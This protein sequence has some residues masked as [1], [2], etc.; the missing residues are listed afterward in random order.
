MWNDW[1]VNIVK[2][3][4]VFNIDRLSRNI[5]EIKKTAVGGS[6][7][8]R[9]LSTQIGRLKAN[10]FVLNDPY[11]ISKQL[12]L[13]VLNTMRNI[14]PDDMGVATSREYFNLGWKCEIQILKSI[15]S[16]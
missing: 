2:K 11:L 1:D 10:T 4:I 16:K 6:T 14:L 8:D 13:S 3:E 7:Y 12:F 9:D 5:E 15:A